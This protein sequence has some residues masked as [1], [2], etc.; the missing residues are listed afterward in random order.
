MLAGYISN[1]NGWT[2]FD[3]EWQSALD[4][5]EIPAFHMTDFEAGG[6]A[7]KGWARDDPRRVCLLEKLA[8]VI[9]RNT[10][11]SVAYGV[12]QLMFE[13]VVSPEV[14]AIVGGAPYFFL[15]TN[16]LLGTESLMDA[17]AKF[18]EGVPYDWE[19][20]YV[21]ARGDKGAGKVIEAYM[22]KKSGSRAVRKESRTVGVQIARDNS[23]HLALQAA[24]ILAFEGRKQVGR[25]LGLHD[26]RPR[27]SLTLLE[28]SK[29]PRSWHFFQHAEHLESNARS[30]YDNIMRPR[31]DDLLV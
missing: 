15:F 18:G 6:R 2:K 19:M 8:D 24:D 28:K 3:Q 1:S 20:N 17:C 31:S 10:T 5:F 4:E 27:K 13:E 22:S 25:Q 12:S 14:K 29:R 21:L 9:D 16:V 30:L 7:F 23:K 11:G 26:R